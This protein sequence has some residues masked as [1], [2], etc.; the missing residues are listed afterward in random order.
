[1]TKLEYKKVDYNNIEIAFNFQKNEWPNDQDKNSFLE[2]IGKN[3]PKNVNFIVYFNNVPIG[4]TGVYQE[5]CDNKSLWLDWFC[6]DKKFRGNGYGK[7]ILLDTI[8]YCKQFKDIDYFR[9]ESNLRRG[10]ESSWL[11]IEVMDFIEKYTIEDT[12]DKKY[13]Y[14]ICTKCLNRDLKYQPWNNKYLGLNE[15]YSNL[16]KDNKK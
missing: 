7:Q 14:Y 16:Q 1:M 4:I 12:D 5:D 10:R 15:L 8:N 13:G 11:Y 2:K 9:V 3:D 6:I